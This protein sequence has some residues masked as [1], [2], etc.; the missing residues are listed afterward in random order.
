[1][2]DIIAAISTPNAVGGISVVRVSGS[3][4]VDLAS[5]IFTPVSGR[6]LTE[7]KGYTAAFGQIHS[8]GE[9]I[10]QGVAL[11]FRGPKSYTGEDTVEI[12]CHGGLFVSRQVLRAALEQGARLAQGGEFTRRAVLNGKLSLTEA[13]GILEMIEAQSSKSLQ[14]ARNLM[15]GDLYRKI[16]AVT[17]DML[18][19]SGHISAFI[20]YPEE[21][22]DELTMEEIRLGCDKAI[23]VLQGL[24]SSFDRGKLIKNGVD[25]VIVGKPNVGKSTLM[26]LLAGCRRSIVTDIPG[27]TRDIVEERINIGDIILNIADT[28]GIRKTDDPIEKLGV[29]MAKE[30]ISLAQ[31]VI[32]VFDSSRRLSEEDR[33][34]MG[35][36]KGIP[37][38]AVC[39]KSDLPLV[40]EKQEI[41]EAFPYYLE[42]SAASGEASAVEQLNNMILKALDL[43]NI[44]SSDSILA[45]ERQYHCALRALEL[46]QE[47]KQTIELGY[48][49]DAVDVSVESALSALL[50]LSGEKVTDAVLD[51]VFSHFCVGK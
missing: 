7:Y 23:D 12:S 49:L 6:S 21:D 36:V 46:L 3:G 30:K 13:E 33:E 16:R 45:N 42:I 32:A 28:A 20:D 4:A 19:V 29:D 38:I 47:T 2:A 48:T 39:N 17:E 8:Q 1:M 34:L 35:W 43:E 14:A 40:L 31:L 10:D 26:N 18:A 51:Q 9:E 24:V 25:T 50:E 22:I 41:R 44:S 15:R 5:K 37:V 27:T 11:V